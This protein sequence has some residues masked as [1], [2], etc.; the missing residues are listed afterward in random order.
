MGYNKGRDMVEHI[1]SIIFYTMCI[2]SSMVEYSL[3]CL[4]RAVAQRQLN[5]RAQSAMSRH[6]CSSMVEQWLTM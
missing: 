2:R 5:G 6:S 3:L 4:G 1:C